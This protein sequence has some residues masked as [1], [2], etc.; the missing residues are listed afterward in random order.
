MLK[1]GGLEVTRFRRFS[2][3]FISFYM[4]IARTVIDYMRQTLK[5][6][7]ISNVAAVYSFHSFNESIT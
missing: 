6:L 3:C 1:Y 5:V 7:F 2:S 4:E